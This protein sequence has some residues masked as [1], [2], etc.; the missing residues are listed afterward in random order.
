MSSDPTDELARARARRERAR[1]PASSGAADRARGSTEQDD[2]LARARES[3]A[4]SQLG[5]EEQARVGR[6][7][8]GPGNPT[9]EE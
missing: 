5:R 3:W 4:L 8:N 6:D 2:A 9:E 1:P 7:D